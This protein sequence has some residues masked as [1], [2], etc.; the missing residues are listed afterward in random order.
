MRAAV[1]ILLIIPLAI[2]LAMGASGFFLMIASMV[3]PDMAAMIVGLMSALGDAIFAMALDG[4]DPAPAAAAAAWQG[5]RFGVALLVAPPV[6]TALTSEA[7]RLP[8]AI[9]QMMIAGLTA[10]LA[11]LALI[12]LNRMPSGAEARVLAALFLTGVVAGFVYW[13]AAGRGA[14]G[15]GRALSDPPSG[16]SGS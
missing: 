7:L 12:G 15:S 9:T 14:G 8:G 11:P 10:A 6:L 1:R 16:S 13:L 3:S 4:V 5:L 2:L